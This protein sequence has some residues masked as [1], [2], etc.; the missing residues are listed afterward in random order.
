MRVLIIVSKAA[1]CANVRIFE[2]YMNL[3]TDIEFMFDDKL[4]S[5]WDENGNIVTDVVVFQRNTDPIGLDF[6][7]DE[8]YKQVI[9]IVETDDDLENV[10]IDSPVYP[11]MH[12]QNGRA[13]IYADSLRYADYVHCSTPELKKNEKYHVFLNA[14]DLSKYDNA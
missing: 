7:K 13:K 9:K 12:D 4:D 5:V 8:D 6:I 11:F 14:I 2:P 10:P 3:K 1:A